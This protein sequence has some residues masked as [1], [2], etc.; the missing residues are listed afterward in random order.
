MRLTIIVP[1]YNEEKTILEILSRLEKTKLP[2]EKEILIIDD[3]STDNSFAKIKEYIKNKKIY[4]LI[5]KENGGKG[6]A[7]KLGFKI[8]TG[9]IITIQDAD[10]EYSPEDYK[11]LIKPIIEKKAQGF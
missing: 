4:G 2:V 10:L 11:K 1:V 5:K 9:D 8:A 7:V 6:S 3:G